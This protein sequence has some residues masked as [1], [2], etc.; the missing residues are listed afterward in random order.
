MSCDV[1]LGITPLK[2]DVCTLTSCLVLI[3][4]PSLPHWYACGKGGRRA[5]AR[6]TGR[7]L[8]RRSKKVTSAGRA[9]QRG[10][11]AVETANR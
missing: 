10:S 7:R 4:P 8:E 11:C 6:E 1:T 2:R 5:A 3:Q 9:G